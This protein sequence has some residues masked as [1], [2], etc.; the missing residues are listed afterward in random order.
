MEARNETLNC[1]FPPIDTIYSTVWDSNN[2]YVPLD[3]DGLIW[4]STIDL[5]GWTMN[6]FTFGIVR[7]AYQDPGVHAS[8]TVS[9]RVEIMEIISSI[10]LNTAALSLIKNN[11]GVTSPGMINSAQDFTTVLYGSYRLYVPNAS[12]AA[13]P[14]FLQLISAGNFGSMEPTAS[15]QLYCY[16]IVKCAGVLNETLNAPAARIGLFGAFFEE[17]DLEHMMRLKRSYELQQLVD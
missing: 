2:G 6:D 10:P 17:G 16:R 11:M 8:T 1:M 3:A 12:L 13:F 4:S 5:S 14:G 9:A 7:T 15:A